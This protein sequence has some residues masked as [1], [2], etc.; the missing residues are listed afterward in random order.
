[1]IIITDFVRLADNTAAVDAEVVRPDPRSQSDPGADNIKRTQLHKIVC[2][3]EIQASARAVPPGRMPQAA[4]EIVPSLPFP[5]L[6]EA[7]LPEPSSN[8]QYPSRSARVPAG[9]T[10]TKMET[11]I[12]TC[13]PYS[14]PR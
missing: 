9:K 11:K 4:P 7:V 1:M 5:E 10:S 14:P 8:L 3:V 13:L 6:S 2:A 12:V